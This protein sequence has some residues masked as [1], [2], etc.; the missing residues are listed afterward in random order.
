[1]LTTGGGKRAGQRVG[2]VSPLASPSLDQN[3]FLWRDESHGGFIASYEASSAQEEV[4]HVCSGTAIR[5]SDR[6]C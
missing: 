3:L 5:G 6:S 1:M 4:S 2:G